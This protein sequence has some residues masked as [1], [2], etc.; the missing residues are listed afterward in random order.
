[1]KILVVEDEES[2]NEVIVKH[3][4]KQGYSVDSCLKGDD[5]SYY[6]DMS[7]YDAVLLDVMLPGKTGWE[8]LREMRADGNDTPVMM[9]TARDSVEDKV[10]GLDEGADDYLTKP[11]SFEELLA[12]IRM[13]TR[14]RAGKHTNVY[15]FEDLTVDSGAKTVERGGE[16]IDLSA[17]E[18]ALLELLIMNKGM[19]LS[20]ETIEEHL[21]DYEYEGASN[22]VD[23]Y[24]R[25]LRKKI[26]ENHARKLIQ[27]VRGQG[28]VMR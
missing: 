4:K 16:M 27:T 11:F 22:M 1:M 5:V 17:K 25:Y 21:W 7:E 18:F 6:L 10:K 9:L 14:K 3:L 13:I 15:K 20:R 26:D 12:R 24:I 8:I 19:V 23:V 2:L 28:Y